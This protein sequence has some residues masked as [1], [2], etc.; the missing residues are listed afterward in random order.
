MRPSNSCSP[1][2][3][4]YQKQVF[5]MKFK[6]RADVAPTGG[7]TS[8]PTRHPPLG[9]VLHVLGGGQ[10]PPRDDAEWV[11]RKIAT[12]SSLPRSYEIF[13]WHQETFRSNLR[14]PEEILTVLWVP[15]V[16]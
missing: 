7:G 10:T 15:K 13:G 2:L 9:M 4:P 8:E 11:A 16:F 6:E 14:V 12:F 1:T 3:A 5:T